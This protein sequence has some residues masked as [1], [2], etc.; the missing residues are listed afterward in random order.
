MTVSRESREE[1]ED[2]QGTGVEYEDQQILNREI[3][4][5]YDPRKIRV[6]SRPLSIS[7]TIEMINSN[8]LDIAPDFQRRKVWRCEQKSLL[9]ESILLRIPLP[10]FYFSADEEGC[11]QVVDGVQRLSTILDFTNNIFS[12]DKLEYLEKELGGKTFSD[13]NNTLWSRRFL[14]TTLL[15]NII[16]PQTPEKV[17][18][19]IFKRLN[20][21]GSPLNSQEI[22]HCISKQRTRDFLATLCNNEFHQATRGRLKNHVR[23]VD[24][25]LALRYCAF[26]L[27]ADIEEYRTM[28]SL[29]DFLTKTVR[30]LDNPSITTDQDHADL[31]DGFVQA[32]D[33]A[34]FLFGDHAFRKWYDEDDERIRP[35]NRALFDVWSVFLADKPRSSLQHAKNSIVTASRELMTHDQD[36]GSAITSGTSNVKQIKYRFEQVK[37]LLKKCLS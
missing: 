16:D 34:W 10:V 29:D 14:S 11:M 9:I 23:M 37:E 13:I 2:N 19:N 7:Q 12:L 3:L 5:P 30:K 26:K 28:D 6:D 22:R 25:E 32:M 15:A 21:G 27:L 8:E 17:K 35:I 18:F 31:R 36:F 24:R 20:T 1:H 33:S 4:R